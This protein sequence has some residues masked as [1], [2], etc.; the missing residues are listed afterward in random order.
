MIRNILKLT[1]QLYSLTLIIPVIGTFI[2]IVLIG[3]LGLKS[4]YGFLMNFKIIWIDYYLT[5]YFL[6]IPAWRVQIVVLIICLMFAILNSR[7]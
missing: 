3:I 6:E 4:N 5:G 1:F 2:N 7:E